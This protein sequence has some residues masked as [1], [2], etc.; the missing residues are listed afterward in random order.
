MSMCDSPPLELSSQGDDIK[1]L[2]SSNKDSLAADKSDNKIPYRLL[3][4]A[5]EEDSKKL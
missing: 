1:I 5:M 4:S 2:S 3:L